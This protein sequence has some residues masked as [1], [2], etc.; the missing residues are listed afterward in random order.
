[1]VTPIVEK[2]PNTVARALLA[3]YFCFRSYP[4]RVYFDQGT[5]FLNPVL[6]EVEKLMS[7]EH[8]FS[9][10]YRPQSNGPTESSHRY[11]NDALS[12]FIRKSKASDWELRI[13]G[14]AFAHNTNSLCT[15]SGLSPFFLEFGRD[16]PLA[17]EVGLRIV[18][19]AISGLTYGGQMWTSLQEAIGLWRGVCTEQKKRL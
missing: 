11:L 5:E 19:E 10:A 14:A 13:C 7:V 16:A 2:H 3:R 12:I 9:S 8:R 17:E 4:A 15:L 1:M 18:G 6:D